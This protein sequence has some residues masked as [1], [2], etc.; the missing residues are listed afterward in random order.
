MSDQTNPDWIPAPDRDEEIGTGLYAYGS[1]ESFRVMYVSDITYRAF[2]AHAGMGT[3]PLAYRW[4][5]L[6]IATEDELRRV[7]CVPAPCIG[8]GPCVQPGC[9]CI[10]GLCKK[11]P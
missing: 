8:E 5:P 4:V 10:G 3:S 6:R 9:L 2:Q 11:E 1:S 7:D